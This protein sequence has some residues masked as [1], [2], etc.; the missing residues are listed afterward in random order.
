MK[1]RSV[2][3]QLIGPKAFGKGL[4]LLTTWAP[5]TRTSFVGDP[6]RIRQVLTNLLGNAV[7]YTLEAGQIA[8]SVEARGTT[9]ALNVTDNGI[10][11]A[12]ELIPTLFD[13]YVQ[14]EN[15]STSKSGL[16]LGLA[17]VKSLVEIHSGTVAASS[18]GIGLGSTFEVVLPLAP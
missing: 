6:T 2:N 11:M 17:L 13:L 9:V 3:I 8:L 18:A 15:L 10:G 4:L 7:R 5:G 14:A 16:G 1:Q 12:P